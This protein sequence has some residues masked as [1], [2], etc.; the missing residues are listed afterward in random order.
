[1]EIIMGIFKKGDRDKAAAIGDL[2]YT[3]PFSKKRVEL[4]KVILGDDYRNY[5]AVWSGS[6]G[7]KGR[8]NQKKIQDATVRLASKTTERLLKGV[9]PADD[10]V[11]AYEGL[12]VYHLFEKYR[13]KFVDVIENGYTDEFLFYSSFVSDVEFHLRLSG[14]RKLPSDYRA[15]HLFAM[16]FQVHRAF[17]HIFE[18]LVGGSIAS[19]K[20]RESI[21]QSIFTHDIRR[22]QRSI[23]DKMNDIPT[24]VT[25][26]SGTGKELVA[27]AVA[28]CG[29]IPFSV[30]NRKFVVDYRKQFHPLHLAAMPSNLIES[31]LFGH[32]KGSYT[33]AVQDRKGWLEEVTP[34]GSVFLDEIGEISEESQIKL[35]RVLQNRTF[36]RLGETVERK[37]KGKIIAATNRNLADAIDEKRF[38]GDLYYRLCADRITTPGLKEQLQG[39]KKELLNMV[40]H[41]S[42]KVI[43][44]KESSHLT[45]ETVVWII[46]NLG[47]EYEWPGNV[48]E[49]EQCVRNIMVRG[50]Y[51]P[52]E[53]LS[54]QKK[55]G[56]LAERI[57]NAAISADELLSEYCTLVYKRTGSYVETAK[58]LSIDRRTVK[59]KVMI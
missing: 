8:E 20:L 4:V 45:E 21:W 44:T 58:L 52:L 49:L 30:K 56:K 43:G 50:E 10:E 22:Y 37:F 54:Q 39:S 14:N 23:F 53:T 16:F 28:Y 32:K 15:P 55:S 41:I 35:L 13:E 33:G 59:S 40:S 47:L 57:E 34:H 24:L 51:I 2:N 18:F 42:K 46:K 29:Y 31:E 1:M 38:R 9:L 36:Q 11:E 17:H 7:E 3:N 25:G 5:G 19:G 12:M 27:R 26:A 6:S 48:R